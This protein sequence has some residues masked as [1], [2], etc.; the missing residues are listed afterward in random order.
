M[1]EP[2]RPPSS[3]PSPGV[4][5]TGSVCPYLLA[6]GG[7]WRSSSPSREHRCTAVVP[8]AILAADKQRRLC[9]ADA[10][11]T[12]ATFLASSGDMEA[13]PGI[14]QPPSERDERGSGRRFVRTAPLVLDHG[15]LPAVPNV[16]VDHSIGQGALLVLMAI[17]FAAILVARFSSGGGET[18][19]GAVASESPSVSATPAVPTSAG[20]PVT[21]VDPSPSDA[22]SLPPSAAPATTAPPDRPTTY[23]VRRGD[24]LSGIAAE[25]GTTIKEL[26]DLNGIADPSHLRVGQVLKLP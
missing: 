19:T 6:A 15:R 17:A 21:T 2:T 3:Q 8:P 18:P 12:C 26:V 10:H 14:V 9:L 25:F 4:P 24:T 7:G 1:A 13:D 20:S 22:A 5:A 11:R 16:R 23:T